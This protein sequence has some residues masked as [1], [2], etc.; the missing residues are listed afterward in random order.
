MYCTFCGD[1]KCYRKKK[2]YQLMLLSLQGVQ[3]KVIPMN[4]F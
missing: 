2:K 1:V 3:L 4:N